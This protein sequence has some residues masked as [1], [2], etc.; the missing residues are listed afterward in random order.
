MSPT[1]GL[2]RGTRVGG[3]GRRRVSAETPGRAFP[4]HALRPGH[5]HLCLGGEGSG[6]TVTTMV[7][8]VS[9]D[10]PGWGAARLGRGRGP[11]GGVAR[12]ERPARGS[13]F[14]NMLPFLNQ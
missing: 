6:V 7:G 5:S 12:R 2:T 10:A 9:G 13:L 14:R 8:G 1:L 11:E 4:S 3:L